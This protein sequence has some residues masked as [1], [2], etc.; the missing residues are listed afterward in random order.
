MSKQAI[1]SI[2]FNQENREDTVLSLLA[3][4]QKPL[5]KTKTMNIVGNHWI[6]HGINTCICI[7]SYSGY[8]IEDSIILNR[9]SINLGFFRNFLLRRHKLILKNNTSYKDILDI[10]DQKNFK[11]EKILNPS[12]PT[13][14][15][16][17]INLSNKIKSSDNFFKKKNVLLES[18]FQK[19]TNGIIKKV[20]STSNDLDVF[21]VKIIIRQCRKPEVGDKFSSRHGQKGICGLICFNKDLPFSNDGIIPDLIMNPHGF[22]SRMTIGKMFEL[23]E[24]KSSSLLGKFQNGNS[25]QE[26]SFEDISLE[27]KSLGYSPSGEDLFFSGITGMPLKSK[28]TSGPIFYQ[29][30]KH[31]VQDK[32]HARSKG[33]RSS[34]TKQP[35]EGRSKGGGLRF[36][37]MERD[38]IVS[39]G[40]AELAIERLMTSSDCFDIFLDPRTGFLTNEK[41]QKKLVSFKLPYAC[42]LL[43]QEM[44]AMNI[45]PRFL[46]RTD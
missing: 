15:I 1:S 39:F 27:L 7:M 34:L 3:Y 33:K 20:I 12:Q 11:K 19:N 46:I 10:I 36:G 9:S 25:F 38:C 21:F 31:V 23:V 41:S 29:K 5:V 16:F 22:P 42:K 44:Q 4:P 26:K 40:A 45:I 2:S 28:I 14:S 35:I 8:D 18:I 17:K 37:E 30:L 6:S 32:I 24:A 43:F 13:N